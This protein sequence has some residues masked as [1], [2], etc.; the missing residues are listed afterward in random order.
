M[1]IVSKDKIL[2]SM[3]RED[4]NVTIHLTF[5]TPERAMEFYE[6]QHQTFL[7]EGDGVLVAEGTYDKNTPKS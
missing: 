5:P 1:S 7:T 3:Y 2:A 4:N 6:S